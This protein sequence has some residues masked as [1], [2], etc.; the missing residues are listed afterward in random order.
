M[1]EYIGPIKIIM[2]P[3]PHMSNSSQIKFLAVPYTPFLL[4]C[5]HCYCSLY[6]EVLSHPVFPNKI[7]P[8]L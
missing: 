3:C 4:P 8:V 1:Q 5:F 2:Q 6:V 7:V